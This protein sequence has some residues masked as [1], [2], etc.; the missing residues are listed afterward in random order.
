MSMDLYPDGTR[1]LRKGQQEWKSHTEYGVPKEEMFT[2]QGSFAGPL[3]PRLDSLSLDR[4]EERL[5]T[6]VII[7]AERS[8]KVYFPGHGYFLTADKDR[9]G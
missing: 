4:L 1:K 6:G 2:R 7:S 5:I 8:A 9:E 3:Q